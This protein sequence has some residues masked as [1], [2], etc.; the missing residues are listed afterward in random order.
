[1][2]IIFLTSCFHYSLGQEY[3]HLTYKVIGKM[4]PWGNIL[5]LDIIF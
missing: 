2:K 4:M 5:E 3:P 1:M